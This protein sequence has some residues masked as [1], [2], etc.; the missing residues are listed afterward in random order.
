MMVGVDKKVI[1][2]GNAGRIGAMG[3]I[4]SNRIER[5]SHVRSCQISRHIATYDV[6]EGTEWYGRRFS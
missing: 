2:I 1:A 6:P 5:T 4:D 3:G